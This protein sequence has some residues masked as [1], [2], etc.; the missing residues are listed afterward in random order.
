MNQRREGHSA[1]RPAASGGL[2][3]FD[4]HPQVSV[5]LGETGTEQFEV[6]CRVN[7]EIVGDQKIHDPFI[8]TTVKLRGFRHAWNAIFGGIKI[9]I[10][11][12]ASEGA[13]RA[14]MTLNPIQLA[15]ET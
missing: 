12:D 7:G 2:E 15:Q 6:K 9:E 4:P 3:T 14:I 13:Q 1:L 11:L 10:A 5:Q 8:R